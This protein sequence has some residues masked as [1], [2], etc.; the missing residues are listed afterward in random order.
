MV[1]E[2]LLNLFLFCKYLTEKQAQKHLMSFGAVVGVIKVNSKLSYQFTRLL[3]YYEIQLK[4][5]FTTVYPPNNIVLPL[6][7][8]LIF[9]SEEHWS[10]T[11]YKQNYFLIFL[12]TFTKYCDYDTSIEF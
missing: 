3:D 6:T 2:L 7:I 4:W 11:Q 8:I 9:I 10:G 12:T 1:W 5:Y